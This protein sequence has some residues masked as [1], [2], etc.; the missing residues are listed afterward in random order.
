MSQHQSRFICSQPGETGRAI[1]SAQRAAAPDRTPHDQT[2]TA[3]GFT[4]I[5]V[6]AA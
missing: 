3:D 2:L 5:R 6:K 1:Q 4:R